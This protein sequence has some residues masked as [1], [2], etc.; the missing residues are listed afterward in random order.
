MHYTCST[1]KSIFFSDSLRSWQ[2]RF[3]GFNKGK[4]KKIYHMKYLKCSILCKM[5]MGKVVIVPYIKISIYLLISNSCSVSKQI[6]EEQNSQSQV[7]SPSYDSSPISSVES[8]RGVYN[9]HS[10]APLSTKRSVPVTMVFFV[11]PKKKSPSLLRSQCQ[12]VS[13]KFINI[14][15]SEELLESVDLQIVMES[16]KM[17][18]FVKLMKM[19]NK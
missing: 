15:H 1:P 2:L 8:D 4:V 17:F 7:T 14:L 6:T 19:I 10:T 13:F 5:K 12:S 18:V 9:Y 16:G 3:Y 11:P